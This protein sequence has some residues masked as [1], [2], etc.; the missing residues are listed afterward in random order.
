[1]M[2]NRTAAITATAAALAAATVTTTIPTTVSGAANGS[3]TGSAAPRSFTLAATT[4]HESLLNLGTPEDPTGNE[5]V[6]SHALYRGDR[7]VGHDGAVCQIIDVVSPEQLRL[8]CIAS[9]TLP[10]GGMTAQGLAVVNEDESRPLVLAIT[11]G[12][13][14]YDGAEGRV[15]VRQVD[16]THS[17]YT[18]TLTA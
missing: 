8:L 3:S 10:E 14:A 17:R 11:G 5:F 6:S 16:D 13:G 7:K 9:L 12:T 1:M 2:R 15:T 4:T 18:F